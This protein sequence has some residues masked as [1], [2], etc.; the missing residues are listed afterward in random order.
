[1]LIRHFSTIWNRNLHPAYS[2]RHFK[3][4]TVRKHA[5]FCDFLLWSRTDAYYI[6]YMIRIADT[7]SFVCM[8]KR[9]S[10]FIALTLYSISL[11]LCIVHVHSFTWLSINTLSLW[12]NILFIMKFMG[13]Q[14]TVSASQSESSIF[15]ENKQSQDGLKSSWWMNLVNPMWGE[16]RIRGFSVRI[17]IP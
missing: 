12:Y 14:L 4:L 13:R 17:F 9:I 11:V 5:G 7:F 2:S 6:W 8:K 10:M 15:E 16:Q 3:G 1:M